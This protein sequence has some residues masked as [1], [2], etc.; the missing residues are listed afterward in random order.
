MFFWPSTTL[1][2]YAFHPDDIEKKWLL[3]PFIDKVSL[4]NY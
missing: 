4:E 1:V 2:E 3:L